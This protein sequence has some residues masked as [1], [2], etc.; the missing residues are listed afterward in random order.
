MQGNNNGKILMLMAFCMVSL[1]FY[2]CVV[3]G[4][5]GLF[6][7]LWGKEKKDASGNPITAKSDDKK[8]PKNNTP[9]NNNPNS[10]QKGTKNEDDAKK[11]K[12]VIDAEADIEKAK[13]DKLAAEKALTKATADGDAKAISKAKVDVQKANVK[14][15]T[16]E[17]IIAEQKLTK[18]KADNNDKDFNDA[19]AAIEKAN[20]DK[21]AAEKAIAEIELADAKAAGDDDAEAKAKAALA[22]AEARKAAAERA[23]K[24]AERAAQAQAE[25]DRANAARAAAEKA[26]ADAR[27]VPFSKGTS[28][29]TEASQGG[30][31]V[32]LD[33][34]E[35][36]CGSMSGIQRF[37]LARLALNNARYEYT[38]TAGGGRLDTSRMDSKETSLQE[39]CANQDTVCLDKHSVDCGTNAVLSSFRLTRQGDKYQYKFKCIPTKDNASL[40]S[41]RDVTT[42]FDSLGG[43]SNNDMFYLDRHDIKCESDE[44]ISQFAL[45]SSG[46]RIQ[47]KYR[48]CKN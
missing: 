35:P 27:A 11:T 32:F 30:S 20:A 13:A 5:G 37:K 16:A 36:N 44:A 28:S 31:V 26:A 1:I 24:D 48:C 25:I 34:H 10:D 47:Y 41:C 46:D 17:R 45:G 15:A 39:Q 18:A 19:R 2:F 21:A 7:Y 14:I 38:C 23:L 8:N 6:Y 9:N 42:N 40:S 3:M 33:R 12:E 22:E 43:R 29:A 4:G